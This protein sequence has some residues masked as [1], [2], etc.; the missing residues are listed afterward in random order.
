MAKTVWIDYTFGSNNHGMIEQ[1]PMLKKILI[2]TTTF[3]LLLFSICSDAEHVSN[4]DPFSGFNRAM[5]TFNDGL[6]HLILKPL[7]EFYLDVT[8]KPI[9]NGV[10][11]FYNNL[12]NIPT[13]VNDL[14]Q[15]NFYQ[16]AGDTWRLLINT[17]VGVFGFID[18]ASYMGLPANSEDMGLT[19]AQWGWKKSTY[20]VLPFFGPSTVRDAVG[21]PINYYFTIY[22]YIQ[23]IRLRNVLYGLGVVNTR[24]QL[25]QL[26]GVIQQAALDQYVFERNAY[27]QRRAYLIKRNTELGDPYLEET[28]KDTHTNLKHRAPPPPAKT[29]NY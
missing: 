19:F 8:P 22:P 7:S 6:D 3:S 20:L 13:V 1:T 27:L 4:K 5:Y 12:D 15:T 14:L 21:K 9:A 10:N 17:T 11:N 18:V 26:Q 2:L 16:A 24:A 29:A 25:L 28:T 23:N